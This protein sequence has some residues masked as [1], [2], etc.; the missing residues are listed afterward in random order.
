MCKD[1]TNYSPFK[2]AIVEHLQGMAIKNHEFLEKLKNP[3]KNIDKCLDYIVSE[4]KR[5]GRQG[6]ADDEIFSMAV[7]YY[8]EPNDQLKIDAKASQCNVVVNHEIQLTESEK[9]EARKRAMKRLE[10]EQYT[11]LKGKKTT[12]QKT[13]EK[14]KTEQMSLFD[15]GNYEQPSKNNESSTETTTEETEPIEE[16]L[17]KE[18]DEEPEMA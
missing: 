18:P 4:V 12:T 15:L 16:E 3:E 6:F 14:D 17:K 10:D 8:E 5:T 9:E 2:K 13:Q 11:L 1:R 7:H